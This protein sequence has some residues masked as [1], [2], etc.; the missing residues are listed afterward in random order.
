M[1]NQWKGVG[2]VFVFTFRHKWNDRRWRIATILVAVLLA[3]LPAGIMTLVELAS[4]A[5]AVESENPVTQIFVADE[6]DTAPVD[7]NQLNGLGAEGY[8]QIQYTLCDSLNQARQQAESFSHSAVLLVEQGDTGLSLTL[9]SPE[10]AAY[11]A[12]EL[13]GLEQFFA[14][15]STWILLEKAGLDASQLTALTASVESTQQVQG[16]GGQTLTPQQQQIEMVRMVFSF[17]LP[18]VLIMALYFMVL[19]YGQGVANNV[20]ME[21]NAKLMD[22]LLLAVRPTALVLGKVFAL[23]CTS[24]FQLCLWVAALVGSFG[25]GCALVKMV[26]PMTQNPLVLFLDGLGE[27]DGL[28]SPGGWILALLLLAAGFFL[29]CSLAAIGGAVAGKP[30]DL[31]STNLLF[32][33]A[34]VI[35][36]FCVLYGGGMDLMNA[37][38][39]GMDWMNWVPFTSILI[40][41]SRLLL[42]QIP[43]W[44]G[45]CSLLL[46]VVCS[47]LLLWLA[48]RVYQ[49]MALYKGNPPS[50]GKL[51][52]MLK[53]NK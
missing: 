50:L 4:G 29:Y 17:A 30:E 31:S 53:Q 39:G 36:F 48:G 42:G 44:M 32:T 11:P 22:T 23:V 9:L 7:W 15:N 28:F 33:M 51:F 52:G 19:F 3:L 10:N 26:N 14:Q 8:T 46:T 24:L 18:F 20:L 38:S 12:D 13:A 6:T 27:M 37:G 5:P 35:S 25:A 49:L 16:E 40:T 1:K 2:K 47:L 45:A 43:L 34:L 21:K 41:P